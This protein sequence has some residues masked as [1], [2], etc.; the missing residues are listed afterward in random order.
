M[1]R[2]AIDRNGYISSFTVTPKVG[3][4][5]IPSVPAIQFAFP[6]HE[7]PHVTLD[8]RVSWYAIDSIISWWWTNSWVSEPVPV[9]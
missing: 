1:L 6:T 8:D 2:I 4:T 3:L 5:S 7:I 9:S